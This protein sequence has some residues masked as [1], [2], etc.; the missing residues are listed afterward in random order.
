ML[1]FKLDLIAVQLNMTIRSVSSTFRNI[2]KPFITTIKQG[3]YLIPHLTC[4]GVL[5]QGPRYLSEFGID[6]RIQ[7]HYIALLLNVAFTFIGAVHPVI[8]VNFLKN[9]K[10]YQDVFGL[11]KNYSL[12]GLFAGIVMFV[13]LG[14]GAYHLLFPDLYTH[15]VL[16][17]I[18]PVGLLPLV[19]CIYYFGSTLMLKTYKSG[20]LSLISCVGFGF[21]SVAIIL[22][23]SGVHTLTGLTVYFL[24]FLVISVSSS[25]IGLR[26]WRNVRIPFE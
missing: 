5:L 21:F 1:Q 26:F 25:G 8:S 10:R 20:I 12:L 13:L 2:R 9:N 18:I 22:F 15:T 14:T 16:S 23:R 6:N 3:L 24:I 19:V 11:L 4:F 7:M 17:N